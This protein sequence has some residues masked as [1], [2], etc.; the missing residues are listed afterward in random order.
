MKK[1]KTVD[2]FFQ[3]TKSGQE[4][5][6]TLCLDYLWVMGIATDLLEAS[7]HCISIG[8]IGTQDVVVDGIFI[9]FVGCTEAAQ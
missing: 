5:W 9:C 2:R 6:G 8:N 1:R 4:N 3:V 7:L